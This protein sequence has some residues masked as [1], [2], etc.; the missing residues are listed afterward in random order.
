TNIQSAYNTSIGLS[1]FANLGDGKAQGIDLEATWRTP[2]AG[3]T[4]T[5]VGN[6]NDSKFTN[7]NKYFSGADPRIANGKRLLNTPT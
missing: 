6:L 4:L 7:V 1:A 2:L 3:L 5:A